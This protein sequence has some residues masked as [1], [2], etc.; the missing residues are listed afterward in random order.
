MKY[1]KKNVALARMLDRKFR[2]LENRLIGALRFYLEKAPAVKAIADEPIADFG[3]VVTNAKDHENGT[4]SGPQTISTSTA[5]EVAFPNASS[6]S[7]L[8]AV[9]AMYRETLPR[10]SRF[11]RLWH[12]IKEQAWRRR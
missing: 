10:P 11:S 7:A 5:V 2:N 12:W 4:I 9:M 6:W 1:P 3:S 8:A